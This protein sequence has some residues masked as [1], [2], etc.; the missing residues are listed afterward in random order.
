MDGEM[1][2]I[3]EEEAKAL[4]AK[5]DVSLAETLDAYRNAIGEEF[6]LSEK[7]AADKVRATFGEELEAAANKV[8]Y[9]MEHAESEAVNL[10][11]AKF[12]FQVVMGKELHDGKGDPFSKLLKE[13]GK[14]KKA[15]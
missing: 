5:A 12:I 3:S 9:L 11:A 15:A 6:D 13:L 7:E 1:K 4:V 10:S 14:D 8:I 2:P